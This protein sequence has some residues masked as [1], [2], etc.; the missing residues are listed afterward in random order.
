MSLKVM[1]RCWP[2]VVA[3]P[4]WLAPLAWSQTEPPPVRG[5]PAL[6][7]SGELTLSEE[8]R[9]GDQIARTL[10]RDPD[11]LDDPVLHAYIQS[12]WQPLVEAAQRRGDMPAELA[13]RFAW[14]ILIGRDRSVNAFALPGG[15]L[16]VYLGLIAVVSTPDELASVLAHELS[17][18]S[19][20]HIAR[21]IAR[22]N[23]QTPW[24][25][26][27][28]IL[29]ALAANAAKNVDIASAAIAGGQALAI[30]SQL[31]FSRDMEREA[32]R[33]GFGIMTEAGFD[34]LG[35]VTMFDKLQA[36]SRL[37]D[38]GAFPYLRSHPLT[39]ERI[40]DMTARVPDL[41]A[42]GNRA[43]G[44]GPVSAHLHA[45]MSAR[46]RVLS[47]SSADR[48]RA[49]AA[50]LRNTQGPLQDPT[51]LGQRYA[52]TLAAAR[53]RDTPLLLEGL[54][55]LQAAPPP[56]TAARQALDWL[57][58]EVLIL[59]P[60]DSLTPAMRDD[61]ARLARAGLN[62]PD[63][64]GLLLGAQ[65]AQRL[66]AD[67]QRLATQRLQTWTSLR[68]RDAMAW[69]TLA[70]LHLVQQQP[71]RAARAEA[72]ARL[73]H[74]DAPGALDRLRAAQQMARNAPQVDHIELSILDAR[75]RQT[76]A[77]VREQARDT[78]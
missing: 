28:M 2:L 42:S 74:L 64:P 45:Q 24:V 46:A 54:R 59:Q 1:R 75:V 73:A 55:Q 43:T 16:G 5:L 78:R 41:G 23:Q 70:G 35:F 39:T 44:N 3:A 52:A 57:H 8:R 27:A 10:Y 13:E 18:V 21:L 15:Y 77:L 11:H 61:M 37:N 51:T 6:G 22:Q 33:I 50:P 4:L 19:Q 29:G 53:L 48:L 34:A 76:E 25:I 12:I 30:Q 38:D 65:A 60:P 71:V 58:L 63:R 62:G 26:G 9:L 32:D 69:Q 17:H 66:G 67:D 68:P 36:A 14:E 7:D 56:D 49:L 40:A 47:E 72:E 31:N 20:R